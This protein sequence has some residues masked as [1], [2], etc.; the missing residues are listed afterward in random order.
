[1]IGGI[2]ESRII[3]GTLL[4][5]TAGTDPYRMTAF[6]GIVIGTAAGAFG[7]ATEKGLMNMVRCTGI[8]GSG[9]MSACYYVEPSPAGHKV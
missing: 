4:Q 9:K 5:M 7:F 3:T 6:V 8:C 2:G 1:M